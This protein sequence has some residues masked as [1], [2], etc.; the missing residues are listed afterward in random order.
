MYTKSLCKSRIW[1]RKHS[2]HLETTTAVNKYSDT[3]AQPTTL[4]PITFGLSSRYPPERTSYGG[5]ELDVMWKQLHQ[6]QFPRN[7]ADEEEDQRNSCVNEEK[8][9]RSQ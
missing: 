6:K 5:K 4:G 3:S 7:G 1:N 9:S 8:R 2:H